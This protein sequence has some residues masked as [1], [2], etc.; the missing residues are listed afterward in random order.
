MVHQQLHALRVGIVV[1]HL[2]IEVGIGGH[3]VEHVAFPHVRPV[4]PTDVPTFY[5]HLV[6]AVLGSEVNVT[7]HVLVVSL[8][9]AVGLHLTPV[10]LIEFDR[11]EVVGVVPTTATYDHLPPHAAVL[12]GMDPR[13]IL[14]LTRLI[15]VQDKIVREHVTGI[16]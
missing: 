6:E 12:R 5:Q 15:E 2:D 14:N 7:L 13:G 3:E 1:E 16:V 11:G 8:V 9:G 4:F 10:D